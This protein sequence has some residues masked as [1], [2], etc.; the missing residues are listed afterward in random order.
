MT[1]K[2]SFVQ[3]GSYDAADLVNEFNALFTDGVAKTTDGGLAVTAL[4]TPNLSVNVAPGSALRVGLFLNSNSIENVVITANTSGYNRYD[5]IVADLDNNV[6]TSVLGTPT[7]SPTVPVLTGNKVALA[8]VLVGNN[9]SVINT[10]NITDARAEVHAGSLTPNKRFVGTFSRAA[11]LVGNQVITIGFAPKFVRLMASHS[12]DKTF[13][14]D[15]SCDGAHQVVL[16]E[17]SAPNNAAFTI[18]DNTVA[19]HNGIASFF[20]SVVLSATDGFTIAWSNGAGT[21]TAGNAL[22]KVEAWG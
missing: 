1:I 12:A 19:L 2:T 5:V 3:A 17:F 14:S 9:V 20:G 6:I 7:S 4:G 18:T 10:V 15:G 8:N 11:N 22:I 13:R 16:G 21:I